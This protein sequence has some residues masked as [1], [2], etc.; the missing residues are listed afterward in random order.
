MRRTSLIASAEAAEDAF[1]DALERGDLD[2]LMAL[3][4][5]D[6]DAVCVHPSGMRL[7]G[8]PAIRLAYQEL[9]QH[10]G[11]SIRIA[12]RRTYQSG[13]LAV[14]NVIERIAVTGRSAGQVVNVIATNVFVKGPIGWQMVLHQAAQVGGA[15]F[16]DLGPHGSAPGTLH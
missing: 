15:E 13:A 11:L 4:A 8:L 10:G 1:Y 2:A 6:E 5:D 7:V 12:E 9:L 14:H 3:W 16:Q